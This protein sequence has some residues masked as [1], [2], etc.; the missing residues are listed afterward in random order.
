MGEFRIYITQ[1]DNPTMTSVE[2]RKANES[3][4]YLNTESQDQINAEWNRTQGPVASWEK[5]ER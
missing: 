3:V 4:A 2:V 1:K 5:Q